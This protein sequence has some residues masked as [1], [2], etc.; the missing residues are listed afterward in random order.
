MLKF[1]VFIIL[2]SMGIICQAQ[3]NAALPPNQK[4]LKGYSIDTLTKHLSQRFP[5][6]K[7]KVNW[8]NTPF[9]LMASFEMG[10]EQHISLYDK[11]GNYME[12]LKKSVWGEQSSPTLRMGFE[13]SIYGLL[14][15]AA[16]WKNI[17][18]DTDDY[19]FELVDTSGAS[20]EVWAD[21]NGNFFESPLFVK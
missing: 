5:D 18:L 20:K 1:Q 9:G 16:F 12:T 14:P 3:D 17:S 6:I 7:S 11:T 15:V 10:Y 19:Y 13:T 21:S 8:S 4:V 2:F